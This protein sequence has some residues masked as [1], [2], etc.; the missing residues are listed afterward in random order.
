MAN[1]LEYI[2]SLQDNISGK[3][4][5]IG[6][7]NEQQL[8][9]WG[10]VQAQVN[11]ANATFN[12][13]G[14]SL[15]GLRAKVAALRAEK[16]WI[17]A[18]NINAIREAYRVRKAVAC[19][20][21]AEGAFRLDNAARFEEVL[22]LKKSQITDFPASMPASDV[23]AWAKAASKPSYTASEVGAVP[24]TRK[25]NGKQLNADVTLTADDVSALKLSGGTVTGS[26]TAT[27]FLQASSRKV[28]KNIQPFE[29][30]AL[31]VVN[32]LRVVSFRY[33]KQS[34]D[35]PPHVGIIA[36]DSPALISGA[37]ND[38]FDVATTVGLLI[39]AVQELSAMVKQM[40]EA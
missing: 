30:S 33:K 19:A 15:G 22:R 9:T 35:Q 27:S 39:K 10:K 12:S 25:V 23:S 32:G 18:D 2:L 3:L 20:G 31:D 11:A 8:T 21:S 13:T 16:E 5:K 34:N 36:E 40:E 1:T 37:N 26:I 14:G 28:K 6:I 4:T 24:D 7:A 29:G 38:S 17:P